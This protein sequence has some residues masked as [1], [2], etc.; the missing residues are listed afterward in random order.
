V[1]RLRAN[2]AA[3]QQAGLQK[4]ENNL[5]DQEKMVAKRLLNTGIPVEISAKKWLILTF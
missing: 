3:P 5:R 2:V 4:R 1:A